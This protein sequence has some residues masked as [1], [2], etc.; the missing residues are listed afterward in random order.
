MSNC[1]TNCLIACLTRVSARKRANAADE[2]NAET[3]TLRS[4]RGGDVP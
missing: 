4:S 1:L 3:I 2:T